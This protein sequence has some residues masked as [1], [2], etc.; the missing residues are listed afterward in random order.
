M[1]KNILI[2][3]TCL[4]F[5]LFL[6]GCKGSKQ[7]QGT[8]K[9][10]DSAATNVTIT[11]SKDT[12][13]IGKE[14]YDY[15]QNVVGVKNSY[16]YYGLKINKKMYSLIIPEKKKDVALL[17]QPDSEDNYL[18]GSLVYAMNKKSQPDYKEYVNEY[19]N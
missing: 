10:Q 1:K 4:G 12:I 14:T 19:L 15:T 17:L 5:L 7:I 11:I 2:F 9:A 13:K 18:L 8:W 3:L 16:R 6:T